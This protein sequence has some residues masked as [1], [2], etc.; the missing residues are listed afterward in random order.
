MALPATAVV[1]PHVTFQ[2]QPRIRFRESGG[3]RIGGTVH[4]P[5]RHMRNLIDSRTDRMAKVRRR[6]DEGV[7]G[8]LCRF[9]MGRRVAFWSLAGVSLAASLA[10]SLVAVATCLYRGRLAGLDPRRRPKCRA[11]C[12][13]PDWH[14]GHRGG[15]AVVGAARS[16]QTMA[17]RNA[18]RFARQ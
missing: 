15:G 9:G 4:Q 17:E 8:Q 2:G 16:A 13:G 1:D 12:H 11:R 10:Q 18:A 6:F 7:R 5:S 14:A 3:L